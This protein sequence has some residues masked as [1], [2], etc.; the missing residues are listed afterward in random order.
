MSHGHGHG[1]GD[2]GPEVTGET[3]RIAIIISVLALLLAI[4]E[5]AGKSAQTDTISHNIET[6]NLWAFF[7]AKTIR[8]TTLETAAD[9]MQL[10][11]E[12]A[13]DPAIRDKLEKRVASWRKEAQRYR[14]EPETGEGSQELAK[15]AQDAS[16]KRATSLA[17]YHHY[18]VSSALF[19]IAIVLASASIITGVIYMLW[20]ALALG[21]IGIV[22]MGI[23]AFAPHAIHV[24]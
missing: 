5:T 13:R 14:S 17:K 22:F 6:A 4:A 8:R 2:H 19:Q 21:A 15:R 24:M 10:D 1:H 12:F 9:A 20:A 11:V 23:A 7:Q 18:E 16:K 3:K